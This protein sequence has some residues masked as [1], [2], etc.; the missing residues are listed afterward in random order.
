MTSPRID[1]AGKQKLDAYRSI[2]D[3]VEGVL[4]QQTSR[5]A[6]SRGKLEDRL[7]WLLPKSRERPT[8]EP[9]RDRE[10]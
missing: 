7:D 6:A 8:Q 3:Q 4:D 9:E 5:A 1:S 10:R 2:P